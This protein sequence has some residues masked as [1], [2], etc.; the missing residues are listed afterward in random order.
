MV[1][2]V[3]AAGGLSCRR[4]VVIIVSCN[5][6]VVWFCCME[7]MSSGV[8]TC[9]LC[10]NCISCTSSPRWPNDSMFNSLL[11]MVNSM[12]FDD[13]IG[14]QNQRSAKPRYQVTK[15]DGWVLV[16]HPDL[17]LLLQAVGEGDVEELDV[18]PEGTNVSF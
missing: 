4:L 9:K 3:F 6:P 10:R 7:G 8:H 14:G 11:F 18:K 16:Q 13:Q 12:N 1:V 2:V 15:K 17:G 5:V